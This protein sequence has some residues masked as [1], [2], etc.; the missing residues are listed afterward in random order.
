MNRRKKRIFIVCITILFITASIIPAFKIDSK[1][2]SVEPIEEYPMHP[3]QRIPD[4]YTDY[5]LDESSYPYDTCFDERHCFNERY[6]EEMLRRYDKNLL[7]ASKLATSKPDFENGTTWYVDADGGADFT[8]IQ[9]ALD[10]SSAGDTVFVYS[11][12]YQENLV[13]N[14]S[15]ILQGESRK[16][17]SIDGDTD[18]AVYVTADWVKIS[19]F[20]IQNGFCGICLDPGLHSNISGNIIAGNIWGIWL[21]SSSDNTISGNIITDNEEGGIVLDRS[22]PNT[23]VG[24]TIDNSWYGI[25][26]IWS[27]YFNNKITGNTITNSNWSG[28]VLDRSSFNTITGNTITGNSIDGIWLSS[29]SDNTISGNIITDN[30]RNG[31]MLLSSSDKNTI[32]G[33]IIT[34]NNQTGVCLRESSDNTI[35][36]NVISNNEY[37]IQLVRRFHY[38]SLNDNLIYQNN[39]VDNG[40]DSFDEGVN[41]SWDDGYFGNYWSDYR[42]RYPEARRRLF[43]PLIWN[44]HYAI[45]GGDSFDRFPLSI[46]YSADNLFFMISELF[47]NIFNF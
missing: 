15:I 7:S 37:G 41:N 8:S 5:L 14:T 9:E 23:I 30:Y 22:S 10:A 40:I 35:V 12:F 1:Q 46:P 34:D 21:S 39:F 4:Q 42:E 29:S 28:I 6:H 36:G 17:T 33:N 43:R 26:L 19:G 27:S 13:V 45:P 32:T 16:T 11:G 44:S 25:W 24:N 3:Y 38:Y 18:T 2:A 20:T 31:I 47:Q